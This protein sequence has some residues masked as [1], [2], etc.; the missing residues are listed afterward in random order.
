MP[1]VQ[2][3]IQ[4]V[5]DS[6]NVFVIWSEYGEQSATPEKRGIY[7]IQMSIGNKQ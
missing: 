7:A 6:Q 4:L 2:F 3:T 1:E 5:L